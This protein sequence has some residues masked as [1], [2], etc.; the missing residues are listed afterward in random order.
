MEPGLKIGPWVFLSG[1]TATD[2]KTMKTV[3][4]VMCI[5]QSPPIAAV[6]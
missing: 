3:G 5:L 6:E 2:Y 4:T 1:V